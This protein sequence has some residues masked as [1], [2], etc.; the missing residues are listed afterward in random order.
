MMLGSSGIESGASDLLEQIPALD[1][2]SVNLCSAESPVRVTEEE[3]EQ[4]AEH[5]RPLSPPR[6]P[7]E[8]SSSTLGLREPG[9]PFLSFLPGLPR[10]IETPKLLKEAPPY[11][12]GTL[13]PDGGVGRAL[14]LPAILTR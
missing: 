6:P 9:G 4:R 2:L 5:L 10:S 1:A 3:E 8:D 14:A 13:H 12:G 7:Q 11:P